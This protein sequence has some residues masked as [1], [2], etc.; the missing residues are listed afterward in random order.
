MTLCPQTG[1]MVN[2]VHPGEGSEWFC[3]V[4]AD[5]G[6]T[7]N[8]LH[9]GVVKTELGRY[10]SIN[11]SYVSSVLLAPLFWLLFKSPVQG[12]QTTLHCALSSS[13]EG[14]TGKYFR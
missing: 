14:V 13:L 5:S 8:S 10:M 2:S 11:R 12:A 4:P 7:V 6:V 3:L 9:P 1:V